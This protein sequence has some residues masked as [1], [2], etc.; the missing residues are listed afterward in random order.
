MPYKIIR[1]F[2]ALALCLFA[3]ASWSQKETIDSLKNKLLNTTTGA[4]QA[5]LLYDL[6]YAFFKTEQLDSTIYYSQKSIDAYERSKDAKMAAVIRARMASVYAIQKKYDEAIPLYKN[7]KQ[8]LIESK[9][10]NTAALLNNEL[11]N[12]YKYKGDLK[13]AVDYLQEN[14]RAARQRNDED[15]VFHALSNL[16][17]FYN[18]N[19]DATQALQTGMELVELAKKK[20]NKKI[21]AHAYLDL[22]NTYLDKDNYDASISY[23]KQSLTLFK[24]VN[25]TLG[26]A[27]LERNIG[28]IYFSMKQYDS[29]SIHLRNAQNIYKAVNNTAGMAD[30]LNSLAG[31][32]Y[33]QNQYSN[34][35]AAASE[36]IQLTKDKE[37]Q[38]FYRLN[39]YHM[40]AREIDEEK[41]RQGF[42]NPANQDSIHR[43]NQDFSIALKEYEQ[44]FPDKASVYSFY[45]ILADIKKLDKDHEG[46][47]DYYKRAV[48]LRDSLNSEQKVVDFATMEAKFKYEAIQDSIKRSQEQQRLELQKQIELKALRYEYEKKQAA[49]KSDE[50]RKKLLLEEELKRQQIE[51]EYAQKQ[52]AVKA[53]FDKEKALANAEQE[54]KSAL[55]ALELKRANNIRN[56]S[57]LGALLLLLLAGGAAWAYIQK[58]KD[59]KIIA[60]EKNK[61]EALLLN[62]LPAEI[63]EE[64]KTKGE[65]KAQQYEEVSVLFTDFVNFT[66]I[67]EQIGVDELLNELNI[68]FT[69]F[70]RIMEKHG[71]EKIKTIG[72][73]YLAVSGLPAANPKH[74]QNAVNAA[75]DILNFVE[76]R[77]NKVPYGLDIRI[78]INSGALIAG[79]I[80][81]KKFAY[82][83]WGD[84]VNIA[85]RM[86]QSGAAGKVNISANTYTF[87]KDDF[88]C[89]HR[90]KIQAK[91]KGEMDMY[92]V[93]HQ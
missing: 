1:C 68:N 37:L 53:R 57:L 7:A 44:L 39:L 70:D 82:D 54:K 86:E 14:V 15:G 5:G 16:Q 13:T 85:A 84:T 52:T 4:V 43:L 64:L 88:K 65:S 56:M 80:G 46:A 17:S 41:D 3:R 87:V 67:S 59:N 35:K 92:F 23:Y 12:I 24:L 26:V 40:I 76:E 74:A 36:A 51:A 89:T 25:D 75:L 2:L 47:F 21:L 93:A 32:Y 83:I 66:R 34:G 28:S 50:E 49:A 63:A 77:K 8:V 69:A 29:A 48:G 45:S 58:R 9:E 71:L 22:G 90:G 60:E 6:A 55:A 73:A 62:I 10:Y 20:D 30:V 79:I 38:L 31:S 11:A 18:N 81:V 33:A 91:G 61:S 27:M 19:Y 72:D 42:L 78:G